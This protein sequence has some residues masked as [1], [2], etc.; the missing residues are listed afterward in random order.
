MVPAIVRLDILFEAVSFI[1][2]LAIA[3][4][5]FLAWRK[6]RSRTLLLFSLGFFLMASAMLLRIVLVSLAF[7]SAS[8]PPY[9]RARFFLLEFQETIYSLIRL[10][11]YVVFLYL[12]A[13]YPL[14]R[15]GGL[16][17]FAPVS[18]IYNPFFEA[19]SATILAFIV[20]QLATTTRDRQAGYATAGFIFLFISHL[21]FIATPLSLNFYLLA[22]FIQMLSFILFL[23]GVSTV[24]KHG[25]RL[26]VEG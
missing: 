5:S 9:L 24:L 21:L 4:I 13:A 22:Q 8:T 25:E 1:L 2:S 14:K 6:V 10:V 17:V 26:S 19:V 7:S 11:S 12:Y 20:Y 15:N 3:S 18:L 23:T 16:H